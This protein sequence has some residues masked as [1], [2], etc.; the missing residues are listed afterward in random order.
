VEQGFQ[1]NMSA[2]TGKIFYTDDGTNVYG[3][4]S[5][6]GLQM[7]TVAPWTADKRALIPTND[8]GNSWRTNV[9]FDDSD[10]DL[11]SGAPGGIGYEKSGG[12]E[13]LLSLDVA[14]SMHSDDTNNPVPS[15]YIRIPFTMTLDNLEEIVQLRAQLRYD[16][17]FVLYLNGLKVAE[18]LAPTPLEWNSMATENHEADAVENIDL[19]S[20]INRLK[21][22][23]NLI[24]IHALNVSL[25]SSDFIIMAQVQAGFA[26]EASG[27]VISPTAKE[28]TG[29]ISINKTTQIKARALL[30]SRW[31]A[32]NSILL[33]VDED[34]SGLRPTEIHYNPIPEGEGETKIDGDLFEFFEIKNISS[35]PINLTGARFTKGISYEFPAGAS[36]YPGGFYVVCS[37]AEHFRSRY[38][39]EAHGQ[40]S[41]NLSNGGERVVLL[42]AVGDTLINLKYNDKLPWPPAADSTGQSLVAHATQP[43]GDPGLPEYWKVS[44][45]LHGSPNKDDL[46]SPVAEN[47]TMLPSM[48]RLEQNYPNPF[49][50]STTIC[51]HLPRDGHVSLAL[52]NAIGQKVE[53][54]VDKHTEAGI[55]HMQW[56]GSAHAGGVY[57]I[58]MRA[59]DF[60]HTIK[61][62][63][64]K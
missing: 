39:F 14:K 59:A 9:E 12:Y 18:N 6:G 31:S 23:Q 24:A 8:I 30:G 61:I 52:Y 56:D 19:T 45:Q 48:Y 34:M 43:Q 42:S 49:N 63:Y 3:D 13:S 62:L 40:Y 7:Q 46:A 47:Q 5:D 27:N 50:P 36:M 17:G 57:F 21:V 54:L 35:A 11:V 58:R 28:Y 64:L 16:D 44:A 60:H 37:S 1:L 51:Y 38:N 10:W 33:S 29:P 2:S 20:F 4:L 25:S 41:G 22:G 53:V 15:C 26:K 32:L 55:H